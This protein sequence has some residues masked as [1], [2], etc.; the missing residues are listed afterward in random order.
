VVVVLRNNNWNELF[1]EQMQLCRQR[2]RL[3]QGYERLDRHL[4]AVAL[5][6]AVNRHIFT[7]IEWV[8]QEIHKVRATETG[9]QDRSLTLRKFAAKETQHQVHFFLGCAHHRL[10]N[11]T[12]EVQHFDESE[13]LRQQLLKREVASVDAVCAKLHAYLGKRSQADLF[14]SSQFDLSEVED[15]HQAL[16]LQ[17]CVMNLNQQME[18][19]LEMRTCIVE[20]LGKPILNTET[21]PTGD[22]Y[23]ESIQTQDVRLTC[24]RNMG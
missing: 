1:A 20:L 18:E 16:F 11:E 13:A 7:L 3:A 17:P 6:D 12:L 21:T 2:I 9:E 19:A 5:Y 22:E 23:E 10:G 4:E 8:E 14:L 15:Q 24:I